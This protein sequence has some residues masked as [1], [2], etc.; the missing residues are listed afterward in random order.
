MRVL[1]TRASEDAGPLADALQA[2]GFEPVAEPLLEIRFLDEAVPDL[3]GLQALAFTSANGVRALVHGAPDAK[4]KGLPVF[5]VGP[6][7]AKAALEAGFDDV[8]S[9]DGDVAAL[10][11][12]IITE[13]PPRLGAVL[14]VAGRHRAGNLSGAL[15]RGGMEARRAVLYEAIA[16]Q[17]L[18]E[19]TRAMIAKGEIGAVLIFSPRTAGLFVSL[20]EDAGLAGSAR[21]LMLVALS[22]A[23]AEAASSLHWGAVRIAGAP[24]GEALLQALGQPADGN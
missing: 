1:V 24:D 5:A 22:S 13:C 12:L 8:T 23:V 11:K 15:E 21:E 14:H 6:M 4:S 7:T 3:S 9:A 18:S 10:A 19:P 2:R 20:M 17:S 16:A